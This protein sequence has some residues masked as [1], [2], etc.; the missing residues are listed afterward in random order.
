MIAQEF[1]RERY[2]VC[3]PICDGAIFRYGRQPRLSFEPVM[4]GWTDD[5]HSRSD[6]RGAFGQASE[7]DRAICPED[8]Q[9][10]EID[11]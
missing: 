1:V 8:Q 10:C 3:Q 4:K 2:G 9:R 11:Y 7:D 6:R 5:F